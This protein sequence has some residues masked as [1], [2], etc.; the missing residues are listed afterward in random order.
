V[1]IFLSNCI[2]TINRGCFGIFVFTRYSIA[3]SHIFSQQ[4]TLARS[5]GND[6]ESSNLLL[7][8]AF[9]SRTSPL[10]ARCLLSACLPFLL[11]SPKNGQIPRWVNARQYSLAV[12]MSRYDS[13]TLAG[14]RKGLADFFTA[15]RT[16]QSKN[17]HS[18]SFLAR[19]FPRYPHLAVRKKKATTVQRY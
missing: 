18:E 7:N 8:L 9:F 17:E 12:H 13:A 3:V 16:P 19:I 4:K 10:L 14:L 15:L 1:G 5:S 6:D 11:H 2:K